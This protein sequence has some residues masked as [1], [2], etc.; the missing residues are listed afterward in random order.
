MLNFKETVGDCGNDNKSKLQIQDIACT[1]LR[2]EDGKSSLPNFVNKCGY[3]TSMNDTDIEE[4]GNEKPFKVLQALNRRG[5]NMPTK[6]TAFFSHNA[7]SLHGNT[8]KRSR[9]RFANTLTFIDNYFAMN[10]VD[11]ITYANNALKAD[12]HNVSD[13]EKSYGMFLANNK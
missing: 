5:I 4:D 13:Q 7:C 1:N 10:N 8:K 9:F 11:C 2:E 6:S 12:G 3:D